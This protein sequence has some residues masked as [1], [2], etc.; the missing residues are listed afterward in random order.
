NFI[1][2]VGDIQFIG[3]DVLESTGGQISL[4]SGGTVNG[5]SDITFTAS[6]GSLSFFSSLDF[7]GDITM[8]SMSAINFGSNLSIDALDDLSLS[9]AQTTGDLTLKAG[10]AIDILGTLDANGDLVLDAMGSVNIDAAVTAASGDIDILASDLA[11]NTSAMA[12]ITASTAGDTITITDKGNGIDLLA[13]GSGINITQIEL[14][15]ITASELSLQSDNTI[16]LGNDLNASGYTTSLTIDAAVFTINGAG[17]N[18]DRKITL[19]GDLDLANS[20]AT[21]TGG[22]RLVIDTAGN[23]SMGQGSSITIP[24]NTINVNA[25]GSVVLGLLDVGNST[26][27]LTAGDDILNGLGSVTNVKLSKTNVIADNVTLN[28]TARIGAASTDAI[29]L[30]IDTSGTINLTFGAENAYI[31]NLNSSNIVNHSA[32]EVIVGLIFSS[33]IIGIGHNIGMDSTN[34]L[35]PLNQSIYD[36]IEADET[37]ISILGADFQILFGEDD[38]DD[39]VSTMMPSVPV[40]I[41]TE[42]GWEF[43]AP[44]RRQ[45]LEKLRNNRN[46]GERFIDWL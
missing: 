44:S 29:T 19:G 42:D 38:E 23:F 41:K 3:A 8:N 24:D 31:N 10:G 28:A 15:S 37:L 1:S 46:R 26:V 34:E 5:N 13:I 43:I 32:G 14:E 18:Q 2:T 40:M 30:D 39:I 4:S 45:N 9:A 16:T 7:E 12:T 22:G 6:S 25:G 35:N 21:V 11:I 27:N 20:V 17:F 33:Q 36:E